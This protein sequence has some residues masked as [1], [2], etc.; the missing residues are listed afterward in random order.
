MEVEIPSLRVLVEVELSDAKWV[1][2]QLDQLNLIEEKRLMA[3]C[4]GQLYQHRIKNV[5]D[6]KV[7]SRRFKGD[8]VLKK[9]LPNARD[10]K[11]KWTPNYKCP[12]MVKHAFSG[13]AQTSSQC[14]RGQT[15]LP[16][17]AQSRKNPKG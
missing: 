7:R 17:K 9:I 14:R 1:Q 16:L 2:S 4:H 10:S 12:Y 15:I 13:G 5:F 3:L 6:K 8:L 11:G